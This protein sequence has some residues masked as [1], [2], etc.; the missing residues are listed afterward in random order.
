MKPISE[1]TLMTADPSAQE[2]AVEEVKKKYE[3]Y[4][5]F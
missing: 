2:K 4:F 1:I 5:G 3:E